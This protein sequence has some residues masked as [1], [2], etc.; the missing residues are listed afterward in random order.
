M[1][2]MYFY[3]FSQI[4][5]NAVKFMRHSKRRELT[6]TDIDH[7]LKTK[8]IEPLYG[9]ECADYIPLRHTSGGGKDIYYPDD[10]EV[11]LV[12]LI[13]SPLPKLPCDVT[14]RAHWLAVE[15]VQPMIPE[16][17]PPLSFQE[18]KEMGVAS[19][20]PGEKELVVQS[21]DV[22]L[23]RKRKK[24]KEDA[25][26]SGEWSKLRPLQSHGLSMEQQL[27]YKELCEACVGISD[28]KR[29]EALTSLSTD[30][31]LYQLLPHLISFMVEGIKVNIAQKK[32][33]TLKHLLRMMKA[34]LDNES[35]S[36]EK[37][38]HEL[39]PSVTSCVLN[40]L[41]CSRPESEDHWMIRDLAAKILAHI[42]TKYSNSV[43]NIQTRVTRILSNALL[44][45]NSG[46]AVHYG[47]VL[48]FAELGP[49]L[50]R[51]FVVPRLKQEGEFIKL[52]QGSSNGPVR[53]SE[54]IAANKLQGILQKHC[55]PCL[56][57]I[58]QP[59]D[60]LQVYQNEYG[61]LGTSLFTQVKALR[62]G[63]PG[64]N[65]VQRSTKSPTSPISPGLK[66]KPPPL[67]IPTTHVTATKIQTPKGATLSISPQNLATLRVQ[68]AQATT[69]P[70]G[71]PVQSPIA[72]IPV[73]LISAVVSNPNV[74]QAVL[75]SQISSA[76][77]TTSSSSSPPPANNITPQEQDCPTTTTS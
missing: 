38:L 13:S 5:Q 58:R 6:C 8:N 60:S 25:V 61:Y 33:V 14:L 76:N 69:S 51:T 31:G 66:L 55:V 71:S 64:T 47:A 3:N 19:V 10:Q 62:Q 57:Q 1:Y 59:T 41:L 28:G 15:G 35:V 27:Y 73:S 16:N 65:N 53:M 50:V 52:S 70:Q 22:R 56:L 24:D 23:D 26:A 44:T 74:A 21:K 40:R 32:L 49:E 7:S 75:A 77:E 11:D 63:R 72:T 34:L 2:I 9:F 36:V 54:Q 45:N 4:V 12:N 42:C 37:F 39:I 29:L 30:P 68:L 17:L 43:N 48:A 67:N 46:L 20:L 18:Q